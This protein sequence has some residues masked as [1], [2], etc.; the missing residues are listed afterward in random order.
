LVSQ[1][2]ESGF[3]ILSTRG[4]MP[5][6]SIK[7]R[8]LLANRVASGSDGLSPRLSHLSFR[9][10]KLCHLTRMRLPGWG[11]NARSSSG[12]S[13][14]GHDFFSCL[15]QKIAKFSSSNN[16]SFAMVRQIDKV[17]GKLLCLKMVPLNLAALRLRPQPFTRTISSRSFK[18]H[19]PRSRV[20]K[21]NTSRSAAI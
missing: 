18:Q 1:R 9:D 13:P 19:Y 8:R 3:E 6:E 17:K 14:K 10:K 7:T 15:Q 20:S 11:Q 12:A 2:Q 16:L 21:H 4:E 5:V